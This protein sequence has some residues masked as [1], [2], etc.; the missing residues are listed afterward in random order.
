MNIEKII[1]NAS[2]HDRL[3]IELIPGK[4]PLI[5]KIRAQIKSFTCSLHPQHA[6]LLG[7]IGCGK[8][9]I[10][11]TM[12]FMRWLYLLNDEKCK[13][14]VAKLKGVDGFDGPFRINKKHLDF[15]E[16][17]NLTGL[18]P[19]LAH[20]QLFGITKGAGTN[21]A[22]R[23]GI[24][25]QAMYGHQKK[26]R[27]P[28]NAKKTGGVVLLDEVG[29]L[30]PELQPILLSVLT[31]AEVFRVGGEGNKDA[32]YS[33]KGSVIAAT[34]KEPS[35]ANIRPDLLSRLSNCVIEL[36]SLNDRKDELEDIVQAMS[37]NIIKHHDHA[38]AHL[39]VLSDINKNKL[40]E[41]RN[42]KIKITKPDLNLLTKQDW[43]KRFDLRG[44]R[45]VLELCFTDKIS[46]KDALEI[47]KS[48]YNLSS[49]SV[50]NIAKGYINTILDM[51]DP[52]P[53]IGRLTIA[54]LFNKTDKQIREEFS[55]VVKND[56]QL[57]SKLA[58]K[59]GVDIS[60]LKTD[61]N[62]FTRDRRGKIA[63]E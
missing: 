44:L 41:L 1:E 14:I 27:E 35:D 4:H 16:E 30:A 9:T 42:R 48:S 55:N 6:L 59:I 31:G 47:T 12:A 33:F 13:E 54:Q 52:D 18:V 61:L 63:T 3:L 15:Y 8:S 50:N 58:D 23:P 24:F 10:A 62:N 51:K 40:K 21:V 17:M 34:W 7:P 43:R 25:E 56:S 22:E 37:E 45:Q 38:A 57:M 28:Q 53:M 46:I 60:T 2:D 39:E 32:A 36:P 19:S 29:D 5:K 11:R 20:S 26:G 49:N